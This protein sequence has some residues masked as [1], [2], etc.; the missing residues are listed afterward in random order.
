MNRRGL[1]RVFFRSMA[2]RSLWLRFIYPTETRWRPPNSPTS[3]HGWTGWKLGQKIGLK[4]KRAFILA[5]DY[6]VIPEPKD[7]HDPVA[8]R[9]DALFRPESI[10]RFRRLLNLG[11]TDALRSTS[12]E[13][14]L[15]TF[16]DFQAGAWPKNNGIRIDHLLMSPE[17]AKL[18]GGV[19][20]DAYVRGW[21]RPSDHVPVCCEIEV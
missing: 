4:V 2:A 8:W 7:C 11:M 20:I 17:A 10:S 3:L 21:E 6:N 12:D 14:G 19:E 9:G 15:Y 16:W 13:A 18:L 5:G 1:S